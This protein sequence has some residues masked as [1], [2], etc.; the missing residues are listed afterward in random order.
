MEETFDND[1]FS[2][3]MSVITSTKNNMEADGCKL[4]N[5]ET[6]TSE[7]CNFV[8]EKGEIGDRMSTTS[9]RCNLVAENVVNV[10]WMQL[11][12]KFVRNTGQLQIQLQAG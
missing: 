9:T 6:L 11:S 8:I 1:D 4:G 5:Y 2:I 3:D 7:K 12:R 10:I